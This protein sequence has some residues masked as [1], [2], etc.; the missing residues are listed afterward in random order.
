[1]SKEQSPGR[2]TSRAANCSIV[3]FPKRSGGQNIK[4]IILSNESRKSAL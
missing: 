1:M 2:G 4:K 3:Q